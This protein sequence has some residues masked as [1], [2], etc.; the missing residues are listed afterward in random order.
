MCLSLWFINAVAVDDVSPVKVLQ[1]L[2]CSNM[3]QS[4]TSSQNPLWKYLVKVYA[5]VL[6]S[7]D[8]HMVALCIY[9]P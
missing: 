4:V 1:T 2:H 8:V 3:A 7:H 9:I 5:Y 6:S